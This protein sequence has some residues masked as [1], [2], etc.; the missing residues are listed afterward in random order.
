MKKTFFW[1][2]G[3]I[4]SYIF[5]LIIA[6]ALGLLFS[7]QLRVFSDSIHL[8]LGIIFFLSALKIDLRDVGKNLVDLPLLVFANILMLII[9]PVVV[10]FLC[11]LI[12]PSLAIPFMILA[13]MP[14]GMTSPLFVEMCDGK[15]SLALMFTIT[16]SLLAPFTVPFVIKL[17]ASAQVSVEFLPMF[18]SL[19]KV[20]FIPF[21]LAEVVKRAF[22]EKIRATAYTFKPISLLLLCLIIVG[23]VAKQADTLKEIVSISSVL[24]LISLYLLFFL[25]HIVGYFIFFWRKREER[26][27]IMICMTYMNFTLAIYLAGTFFNDPHIVIPIVLAV[28]PWST[29][30]AVLQYGLSR[31]K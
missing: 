18:F 2:Y 1:F 22:S 11:T 31:V 6:F 15:P 23:I 24:T 21:L 14:C 10:Y 8:F 7:D 4:E 12:I 13:A 25:F 28:L 16:T 19:M 9:F 27:S 5:I 29:L 26:L 3:L 17:M 20:I 30:I